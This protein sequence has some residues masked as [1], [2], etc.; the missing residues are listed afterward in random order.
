VNAP[1]VAVISWLGGAASVLPFAQEWFGVSARA[2]NL[3][4]FAAI[5]SAVALGF[6][7]HLAPPLARLVEVLA[8]PPEPR[9]RA[10]VLVAAFAGAGLAAM[11][12]LTALVGSA[13]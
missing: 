13:S 3:A 4:L 12:G 1:R 2:S 10:L 7:I 9:V 11:V 5:V 6:A 8:G